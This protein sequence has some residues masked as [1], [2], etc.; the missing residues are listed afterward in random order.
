MSSSIRLVP[1]CWFLATT[2]KEL[3]PGDNPILTCIELIIVLRAN[4]VAESRRVDWLSKV[5][6]VSISS[7][8]T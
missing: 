2:F 6:C 7:T 5:P 1:S 4:T 8:A 3:L